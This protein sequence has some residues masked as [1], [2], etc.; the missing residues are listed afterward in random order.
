M[1]R[2]VWACVSVGEWNSACVLFLLEHTNEK[3][4]KIRW[5]RL[6][7]PRERARDPSS[8]PTPTFAR[9]LWATSALTSPRD[10]AT[11]KVL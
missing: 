4:G 9:A 3:K 8:R 1:W 7:D 11:S 6:S 10:R 5:E 2:C